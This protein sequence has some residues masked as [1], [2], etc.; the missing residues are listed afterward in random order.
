MWLDRLNLLVDINKLKDKTVLIVGI[1]GVGG[2]ALE[3]IA[4]SGINNIIIV[5]NDVV[6]ITNLNRQIISN[7]NNVGCKKIEVAK[8]RVLGINKECNVITYD[9]FL[10]DKNIYDIIDNHQIDYIIDA[11]DTMIV[12]K[13]LI[14]ISKKRNIKLITSMG[15]ANKMHPEK[16]EIMDIRKTEYDPV[17]KLIRKMIK[18]EKINGKVMCVCSKEVPIKNKKLGSN[19]FVPATAG[20]LLASYVINDIVGD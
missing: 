1:G 13:E 8:E 2:Y 18:D 14:R 17:A 9:L 3:A 11:C 16:L 20:L 10:D 4:R 12:K 15:T 5:D 6:D 19:A 7:L